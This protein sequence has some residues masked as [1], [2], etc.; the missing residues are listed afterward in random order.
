MA[1]R[2]KLL[3]DFKLR[4]TLRNINKT[5]DNELKP[6]MEQA[7]GRILATQQQLIPKD[8]GDA[9]AAL[10]MYVSPSGLDAQIGIRGK[11]D[12]RRFYY[13]RFIEYG[14][15]GYT[16]GKRAGNR[17]KRETNKSDGT[18]FFGKHPNIPARP[19]HPWLRP[20]M[21]VNREYVLADIETAIRRTLRKASLGAG[22]G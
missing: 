13:L 22:N 18:H 20:S 15:K 21:D 8:T 11:R 7:A 14:T 1:R 4:R 17:S 10:R 6:A 9:A 12:N 2:S 19:A 5:M 3:G 16:G